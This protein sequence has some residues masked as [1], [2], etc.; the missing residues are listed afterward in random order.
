MVQMQQKKG[1]NHGSGGREGGN[2]PEESYFM[3][4]E[5]ETKNGLEGERPSHCAQLPH[6][7]VAMLR[8]LWLYHSSVLTSSGPRCNPGV[9]ILTSR[10][11]DPEAQTESF[12]AHSLQGQTEKLKLG[13]LTIYPMIFHFASVPKYFL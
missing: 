5:E 4:Q 3:N 9:L 11:Q 1:L 8:V 13:L 7:H 6:Y 12:P 2:T 10:N